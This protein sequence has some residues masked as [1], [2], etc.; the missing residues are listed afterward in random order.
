LQAKAKGWGDEALRDTLTDGHR[1]PSW[2][3]HMPGALTAP[4]WGGAWP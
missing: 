1:H 4:C 3:Q 2:R